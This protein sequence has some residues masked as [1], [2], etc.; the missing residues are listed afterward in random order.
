MGP[1]IHTRYSATI[2]EPTLDAKR[3]MAVITTDPNVIAP[4]EVLRFERAAAEAGGL[5]EGENLLIRMAGP[6]N[7]PVE[8]TRRWDTGFRLAATSGHPQL[9]QFELS[10]YD[11][12][13][14]LAIEIRTRERSA[15]PGFHL[16]RRVGLIRR[17][18]TYTWAE[19]LENAGQLA[20]GRPLARITVQTWTDDRRGGRQS[21]GVESG[22]VRA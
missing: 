1:V 7:A 22:P 13:D 21:A 6:W 15:G 9:G 10:G 5:R 8:V 3:L 16:L 19:M 4:V 12:D 18:Q 11:D 20:G 2:E 17:M 14:G